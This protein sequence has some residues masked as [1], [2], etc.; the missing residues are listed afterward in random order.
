MTTDDLTTF[1]DELGDELRSLAGTLEVD[2]ALTVRATGRADEL[3]ATA[4]RR[5]VLVAVAA[6]IGAVA[7]GTAVL[8]PLLDRPSVPPI[9]PVDTA[10]TN[11]PTPL[12]T[13]AS[14]PGPG[15]AEP[16]TEATPDATGVGSWSTIPDGPILSPTHAVWTGE[17]LLVAGWCGEVGC[18]AQLAS[19]DPTTARWT[20]LDG[21]PGE[22]RYGGPWSG[23]EAVWTGTQMLVVGGL[24]TTE[25]DPDFPVEPDVAG[26]AYTP[27]SGAWSEVPA[28]PIAPRTLHSVVWTGDELIVWGG[29]DATTDDGSLYR[30]TMYADGA[31]W[32]PTTQT[33]RTLA[34]S[35]L[36]GR[37]QHGAVWT[38]TT[39][40]VLGGGAT[41][42]FEGEFGWQRALADGASYDPA[43]DSWSAVQS[44]PGAGPAALSVWTGEHRLAVQWNGDVD[45]YSR[46]E[47]RG[48]VAWDPDT[49]EVLDITK[50]ELGAWREFRTI[51]AY[52]PELD[53][54][55]TWGGGCGEGCNQSHADGALYDMPSGTWRVLAAAPIGGRNDAL[56]VWTGEQ[57]LI[58]GGYQQGPPTDETPADGPQS[59]GAAWS[60]A[61]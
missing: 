29:M 8:G 47:E 56:G 12:P 48:G 3:A 27:D 59:G 57:L 2:A 32:N 14:E 55:L 43:T 49:T 50:P 35:P 25:G 37:A 41:D 60:P 53:A 42:R 23:S 61:P 6:A 17:V 10:P 26:W 30:T 31:A 22:W 39:M 4:R 7:L 51:G 40:A 44:L 52:A 45:G 34:P 46:G 33:W 1:G 36:A 28:A 11:P 20:E 24:P 9:G 16:T 21:A 18:E 13:E 5:T 19:Y 38:D 54:I 58:V 15:V